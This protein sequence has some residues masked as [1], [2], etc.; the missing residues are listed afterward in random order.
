MSISV[1]II[2]AGILG[3]L[4]AL[5]LIEKNCRVHLFEAGSDFPERNTSTS[6]T[7][8]GM[9]T[10]YCELEYGEPLITQL[11]V[12][13]LELWPWLVEKIGGSIFF[14]KN[15]SLV[16][17]HPQDRNELD[18]LKKCVQTYCKNTNRDISG[19]YKQVRREA[20]S[21]LEPDLPEKFNDGLLFEMEGQISPD[22]I[23]LNF[24]KNILPKIKTN[25]NTFVSG[26]DSGKIETDK[27]RFDFDWVVDARGL[28]AK[29][30][31]SGLRGV[32]GEVAR[33]FSPEIKLQRPIR[34]M[35]PRYPI[36]IVPR[37]NSEFIIGATSIES[38]DLSSVSVRS[39]LE[40]L[41]A[42]FS[43]HP[44]FGEARILEQGSQLRP[45][46]PNNRPKIIF[47]EGLVQAN[48]LYRHGYLAS[49]KISKMVVDLILKNEKDSFYSELYEEK[50]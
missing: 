6:L 18:H 36:Y 44:G 16:L 46:L 37:P 41:S 13:S 3:R 21:L 42:A 4:T 27:G 2:G 26:F 22:D 40:L 12:D 34:I 38:E 25:F 9:I 23:F 39:S 50:K 33:L 45:A 5:Q 11:G 7:A 29:E 17:S 8:A 10:P 28:G 19:I 47:K 31:I 1:G 30:N 14:K 43:V 32:R 15:G 48:G 49:P 20:I 35:H 24:N